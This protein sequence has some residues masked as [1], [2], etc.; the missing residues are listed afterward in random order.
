MLILKIST[1]PNQAQSVV[2]SEV[3]GGHTV[4]IVGF[5]QSQGV[6]YWIMKNS[7]EPI[8]ILMDRYYGVDFLEPDDFGCKPL[9]I[10]ILSLNQVLDLH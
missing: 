5:I 1:N 4:T 6:E 7:W 8:K 9:V 2:D 10:E 3:V